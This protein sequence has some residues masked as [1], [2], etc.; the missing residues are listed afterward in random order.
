MTTKLGTVTGI[1]LTLL[2][3][4]TANYTIAVKQLGVCIQHYIKVVE[5]NIW[6]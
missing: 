6:P 2:H 1:V 3:F 5:Y 4:E